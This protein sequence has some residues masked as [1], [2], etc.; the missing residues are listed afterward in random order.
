[1]IIYMA[2]TTSRQKKRWRTYIYITGRTSVCTPVY[3]GSSQI[4]KLSYVERCCYL[5]ICL[6]NVFFWTGKKNSR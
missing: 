5:G 6:I 4:L 2:V 3:T 1:M